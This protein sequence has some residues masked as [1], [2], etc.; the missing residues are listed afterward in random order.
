ML[1]QIDHSHYDILQ[2][3]LTT[4]TTILC[5]DYL[6]INPEMPQMLAKHA[7]LSS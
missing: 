7:D 4:K 1:K 6:A 3:C 5:M 2:D